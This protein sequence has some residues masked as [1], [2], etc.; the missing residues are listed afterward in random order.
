MTL[1]EG[2][3][4]QTVVAGIGDV[5][6]ILNFENVTG[7]SGND[8][9]TGNSGNNRLD[10]ASSGVDWLFGGG[11][12]DFLT[13]SSGQLSN[14][15]F[16]DGGHG[17]D[18]FTFATRATSASYSVTL[19]QLNDLLDNVEE[20][21]FANTNNRLTLAVDLANGSVDRAALSG[22]TGGSALKIFYNDSNAAIGNQDSISVSNAIAM[23]STGTE[24]T[25]GYTRNYY[26]DLDKTQLLLTLIAV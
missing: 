5:D 23:D 19:S 7:G 17:I 4:Q 15:S 16:V 12:D 1:A 14:G 26:A 18:R 2:G 25:S 24:G 10:G 21:S 20:V 11:G 22:I 9:I 6:V 3:A 8:S 13:L